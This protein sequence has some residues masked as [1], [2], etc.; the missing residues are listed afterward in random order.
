MANFHLSFSFLIFLFVAV[1]VIFLL[2]FMK[3]MFI[4]FT[5]FIV[6]FSNIIVFSY[7][8]CVFSS[9]I[10]LVVFG[11]WK[12]LPLRSLHNLL[13]K[14]RIVEPDHIKILDKASVNIYQYFF[15]TQ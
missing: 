6:M 15:I 2:L 11:H 9:D 3:Q 12:T 5:L 4:F 1:Y 13:I 7:V 8:T 10:D 14:K